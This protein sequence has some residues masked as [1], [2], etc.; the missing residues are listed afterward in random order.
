MK[1]GQAEHLV[2]LLQEV[3]SEA[4]K[5]VDDLDAIGVG[6]GPGNFTGIR[7]AVSTA[8]GLALSL[9]I[10]AI[11]VSTFEALSYGDDSPHIA[12]VPAPRDQVYALGPGDDE[13]RLVAADGDFNLPMCFPPAP[14]QLAKNIARI[15]A[16]RIG[17]AHP[18]PAP[19]Y[20]KPADAAPPRDPAPVILP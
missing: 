12:A 7:I 17:A 14:A 15:A 16:T 2:P 4:G 8:R 5:T 1:R 19:L 20:V 18:R 6:I 10:D 11:G 9:G 13:P 3:L